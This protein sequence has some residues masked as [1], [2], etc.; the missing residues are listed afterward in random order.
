MGI[1]TKPES[2]SP[3]VHPLRRVA[4]LVK[5]NPLFVSIFV[6]G[7]I[8]RVMTSLAYQ[9]ALLLQRDAYAY[10]RYAFETSPAGFRPV[11]YSILIKPLL[12]FGELAVIPA[13]QHAVG[14]GIGMLLF[15]LLRR[16]GVR[17]NLAALGAAPVLLDGYQLIIEQYILTET[18]FEALMVGALALMVWRERPSPAAVALAGVLLALAALTRFVGVALIGPAILYTVLKRMGWLRLAALIVSFAAPLAAY[19]LWVESSTRRFGLTHRNG[20]FLYGRVAS[21]ADCDVVEIPQHERFL[22]LE[23]P[24]PE[25]FAARGAFSLEIP[26]SFRD[27]P[28]GN[29]L[30]L[31]FS[32]RMILAMP[33]DYTLV[34]VTDL[35]RFFSWTPPPSQEPNVAR[36][37]F[38]RSLSEADPLPLID[39]LGGSPPP[40]LGLRDEFRIDPVLGGVL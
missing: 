19:S 7:V 9:P 20:F 16:L 25:G 13:V 40:G 5:A 22:C 18:F 24:P 2:A 36:W 8:L 27:S 23:R 31:D 1:A 39:R 34:V 6:A 37:R 14:L 4:T 11:F 28:R 10:L 26:K 30:M 38:P 29:A 21:F 12:V 3:T 35:L 15:A 33:V 17:P 32:R